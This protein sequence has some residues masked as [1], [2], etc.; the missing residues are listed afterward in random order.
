[1][2]VRKKIQDNIEKRVENN[3]ILG[4]GHSLGYREKEF[5]NFIATDQDE[6]DLMNRFEITQYIPNES[7]DVIYA[8]HVLEHIYPEEVWNV[9]E[10]IKFMN[11]PEG[12]LIFCVPDLNGFKSQYFNNKEEAIIFQPKAAHHVYFTMESL[13]FI[14]NNIGYEVT[15]IY[16]HDKKGFAVRDINGL[17]LL[18]KLKLRKY[19]EDSIRSDPYGVCIYSK[20]A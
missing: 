9:F 7:I 13:T 1:M 14:L 12:Y 11:K 18:E 3:L 15:P 10:N 17:S 16:Y 20:R 8:N 4:S 6:L 19:I 5:P 2:M